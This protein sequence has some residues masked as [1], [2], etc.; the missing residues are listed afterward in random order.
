VEVDA[1]LLFFKM[2][3]HLQLTFIALFFAMVV[4]IP[5]GVYLT[6]LKNEK[7]AGW[8][9]RI[10]GMIQTIPGLALL[11]LLVVTFALI[12]SVLPVPTTGFFPAVIVL[13]L[14]GF[15]PILI[16]TYSGIKQVSD[17]AKM[18]ARS[19]GMTFFQIFFYVELPLSLPVILNG[20]QIALVSTI[21]MVTL[22][23][24]IG[25]GGL[26]DL[27]IQ[28]LRTM[29]ADLV[30]AGT[31]PAALLAVAFD[32]TLSRLSRYLVPHS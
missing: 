29:Q 11:A 6:R 1:K 13:V 14:Y 8:V 27:I 22:T 18:V 3:E 5:L 12:H 30:L 16:N 25:S 9:L 23:S 26:G 32:L 19:M 21:G 15:L 31:I 17:S 4:A 28:G 20:V 24:L 2:W 10:T 7:I